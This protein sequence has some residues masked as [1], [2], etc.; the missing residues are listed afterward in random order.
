[1]RRV[2]WIDIRAAQS[3]AH[4]AAQAYGT[5]DIHRPGS[6][7]QHSKDRCVA[8]SSSFLRQ[9]ALIGPKRRKEH[10]HCNTGKRNWHTALNLHEHHMEAW[11][12][13]VSGHGRSI[14]SSIDAGLLGFADT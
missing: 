7:T 13:N 4:R 11:V 3:P 2:T 5:S 10:M 6:H 14:G 9:I 12:C 1:M 8:N